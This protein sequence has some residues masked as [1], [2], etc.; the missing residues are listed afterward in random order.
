MNDNKNEIQR[1]ITAQV[2]IAYAKEKGVEG[3]EEL[4]TL[5]R[6]GVSISKR[7]SE[8]ITCGSSKIGGLPDPAQLHLA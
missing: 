6:R 2:F 4:S 1:R 5:F 3:L 7:E 8:D